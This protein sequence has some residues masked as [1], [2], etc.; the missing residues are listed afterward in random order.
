MRAT[1]VPGRVLASLTAAPIC[2]RSR[3]QTSSG[4]AVTVSDIRAA[5]ARKLQ[6]DRMAAVVVGGKP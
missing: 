6:P 5:F 4:N 2:S 1:T 3:R